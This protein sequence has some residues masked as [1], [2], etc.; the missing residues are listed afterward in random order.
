MTVS[1][2]PYFCDGTLT[3]AAEGGGD[4]APRP[5]LA[6]DCDYRTL[7]PGAP[8][9]RVLRELSD[10]LFFAPDFDTSDLRPRE[11]AEGVRRVLL[12]QRAGQPT[13]TQCSAIAAAVLTAGGVRVRDASDDT[14]RVVH[15]PLR[16]EELRRGMP[17]WLRAAMTASVMSSHVALHS[18][19]FASTMTSTSYGAFHAYD[20]GGGGGSAPPLVLVHGMF[21]TAQS[22]ALLGLLLASGGRCAVAAATPQRSVFV[23]ICATLGRA[24]AAAAQCRC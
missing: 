11:A 8:P 6:A 13:P 22:M 15:A 14:Y 23:G 18:C 24:A 9:A 16:V 3:S 4:P 10:A 17:L 1:L 19:G 7:F 5:L 2:F 12:L 21:T 20:S